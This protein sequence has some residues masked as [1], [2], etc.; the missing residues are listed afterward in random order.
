MKNINKTSRSIHI[1]NQCSP[2]CALY[3][4][5]NDLRKVSTASSQS[6]RWVLWV[7]PPWIV[8]LF[9]EIGRFSVRH[10]YFYSWFSKS[11]KIRYPPPFRR[12]VCWQI[13]QRLQGV[14]G[15]SVC[16]CVVCLSGFSPKTLEA[17]VEERGKPSKKTDCI[18]YISNEISPWAKQR[19][20]TKVV[21]IILSNKTIKK[22][23]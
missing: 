1:T 17:S 6:H 20:F 18:S 19:N 16:A 7:I 15:F 9:S 10:F 13:W 21:L 11:P 23:G 4:K 14:F 3:F 22:C 12:H 5:R 2:N 8:R